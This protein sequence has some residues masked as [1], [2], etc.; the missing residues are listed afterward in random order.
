[1]STQFY[2]KAPRRVTT[3]ARSGDRL[4]TD[5]QGRVKSI[6]APW[7]KQKVLKLLKM[8]GCICSVTSI[9]INT[10]AMQLMNQTEYTGVV[11]KT[12]TNFHLKLDLYG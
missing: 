12:T 11:A 5:P 7:I 8:I 2:T 4:S 1:M 9:E 10:C 3:A 6:V